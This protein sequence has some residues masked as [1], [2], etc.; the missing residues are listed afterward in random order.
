MAK[1]RLAEYQAKRD[2][3]KTAEP[4]G[5]AKVAKAEYPRFVI[6]KHAARRPHYD[7]RLEHDGVFKS[8]AVTKGP[9]LDPADKRL[10]VEV[11]DHPL[12]YG[13]FEGTIPEGEYG[14][15]TVMLW[16][17]GFWAPEGDGNVDKALRKGEL[18]F[19]LAG[20]KLRGGWVLVRMRHDREHGRRNNW[21]LIKH[22]DGYEREG[23]GD[24][25]LAQDKSVAS[26]RTMQQ[27]AAGKGRG[28]KPFMVA[29]DR[30]RDPRAIWHS[31]R[32]SNRPRRGLARPLQASSAPRQTAAAESAA[33][34]RFIP[35]QLC[36]T[37]ANAP[38]GSDWAHEIKFDG[39]RMQLRV[40]GGKAILRTR[41]GLDWT[42][43][44]RATAETA[45]ALPDCI[46]DGEV[47]A[48]IPL[49]PPTFRRYRRR[50]RMA[51]RKTSSILLSI[52]SLPKARTC[53]AGRSPSA[54]RV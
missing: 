41:K 17:R 36:K 22:R 7:L 32:V 53:E 25:A 2:F 45:S 1:R 24:A 40:E 33:M 28:P 10:A 11:E 4:S 21:L 44:F 43:K 31:N 50:S 29:G 5:R 16:D 42:T 26:E 9:S 37:H 23:D 27:I 13:D 18:K 3:S 15:G 30:A 46:L 19:T 39:Y 48:S 8:W 38:S 6:Q 14:G 51:A 47:V 52:F 20:Q 34:P 54:R 35:P 12:D 49:V